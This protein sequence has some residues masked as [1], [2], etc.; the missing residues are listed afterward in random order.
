MRRHAFTLIELLVVIA[1]IGIL[2]GLLLPAVQAARE[3]AR[4]MNC[5]SNL[6]QIGLALHNFHDTYQGVPPQATYTV[7]ST[8]SGYSVHARLLPFIEQ[9]NVAS[10]VDFNIGYAA[11]P[12]I[13]RLKIP[14]YRCP[15]D[16]KDR[17]RMDGGIEFY[18]TNYGFNIGTWL[19]LDQLT[20]RG[21][22]GAFGYN[23]RHSF[24]A[25]SDGLSNTLAAAE[26]KSFTPALLD[27]GNPSTDNA[28]PPDT[29]EQVVNFGGTFDR[30]FCHTQWVTGR[31]LQ[32]GLTTTFPPNTRFPYVHAGVVYDVNFTSARVSPSAPRHGYRVVTSRSYHPGGVNAL[33]LDGSV[34]FVTSNIARDTWRAF[35]TRDGGEIATLDE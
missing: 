30:D 16:P 17:T 20:A 13:C 18:P 19:G 14:L 24:A 3:A 9:Y 22:D 33:L 31:T 8:F 28:P 11:Q 32:S 12:E 5:S 34:R 27:G 4:R 21:G 1:I 15:S 25:I 10:R 35:G 2:I 29:P 7:G 6:K 26:V 23:M